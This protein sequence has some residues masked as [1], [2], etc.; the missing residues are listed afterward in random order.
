MYGLLAGTLRCDLS[1]RML[2]PSYDVRKQL[3]E[4]GEDAVKPD[5]VKKEYYRY[6]RDGLFGTLTHDMAP[7]T[8]KNFRRG[9]CILFQVMLSVTLSANAQ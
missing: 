5:E 1:H 2:S 4:E 3:G 7:E 8:K 6:F 9:F